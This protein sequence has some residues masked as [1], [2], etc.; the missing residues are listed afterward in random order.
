MSQPIKVQ[1]VPA[2]IEKSQWDHVVDL[3]KTVLALIKDFGAISAFILAMLSFWPSGKLLIVSI[4]S[5]SDPI[6][7]S[8]Q[9]IEPEVRKIT[10]NVNPSSDLSP[11]GWSYLGN[12]TVK[13]GWYYPELIN[14]N[15]DQWKG[16]VVT[17]KTAIYLR[18]EPVSAVN[19]DP[20]ALAVIG[21]DQAK[22]ECLRIFDL[23]KSNAGSI[24]LQ[25]NIVACSEK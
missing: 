14:L 4:F 9:Q 8:V 21:N 18:S 5:L 1:I 6:E 15:Q 10:N 19:P 17:P 3:S 20:V 2:E 23:R 12:E 25:G 13:D 16:Q 7:P 11:L 22:N 24:W